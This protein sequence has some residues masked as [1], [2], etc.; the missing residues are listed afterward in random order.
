MFAKAKVAAVIAGAI[1]FVVLSAVLIALGGAAY[2]Q[3]APS[4]NAVKIAKEILDLK[5]S[6]FLFEPM[7]PGVIERVKSMLQQ[8][9]P[10]LIKDLNL[11][12]A[13]LRKTYA[14]RTDELMSEIAKVYASRFTEGELKQIAAFYRTPAG[15]KVIEFEPRIFDDALGELKDWQEKFAAEVIGRFRTEMK[16]RGHDL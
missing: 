1:R 9:N 14:P 15:K 6:R 4:A 8:T 12:A 13:G 3:S 7:V 16:K 11:V 5:N 2:A 10:M